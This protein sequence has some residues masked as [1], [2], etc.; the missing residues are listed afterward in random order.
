MQ[1]DFYSL[2]ENQP[3]RSTDLRTN[4]VT[5]L[6]KLLDDDTVS[7]SDSSKLASLRAKI[8]IDLADLT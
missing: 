5:L 3:D 4:L 8:V 7:A 2:I 1:V 6:D